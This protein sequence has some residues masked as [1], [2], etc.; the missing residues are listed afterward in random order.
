MVT[1]SV[2]RLLGVC[3]VLAGPLS[4]ADSIPL[5]NWSVPNTGLSTLADLGNPGFFVA[6]TPCRVADTRVGSGFSG[7]YGA[8]ALTAAGRTM[9][10]VASVCTGL[11]ANV[12]AF[13]LNLTVTNTQGAG[14]ILAYP[15]GGSAPTVSSV[16]Y[17]GAGQT[18]ANAAIVPAGSGDSVTF[19]AGVSN[20]DLIVDINGYFVTGEMNANRWVNVVGSYN[21][22]GVLYARN[23]STSTSANTV[24]VRGQ[25]SGGVD[26]HA[27]V[28]GE[29]LSVAG[30][31]WGVLGT[32][33][34]TTNGSAAILGVAGTQLVPTI[35]GPAAV[36]GSQTGGTGW[37]VIGLSTYAGVVGALYDGGGT[38]QGSGRL[39]YST[40]GVYSFGN[41]GA[42][43]TKSFVE[44]HP[45]D[46]TKVIKYVSLEGPEAGTYF[47]GRGRF[48]GGTARIEVPESFRMVSDTE[49][50]TV[51]ITPIGRFAQVMVSRMDL[52]AI[53]VESTKDVE[54]SYL[55]Q[56][57]RKAYREFQP[58]VDGTEYRPEHPSET[59]PAYLS[60]DVKQRLVANGTYNADGT[61]NM[62]TAERV[63]WAKIWRDQEAEN[64]RRAQEPKVLDAQA[65]GIDGKPLLP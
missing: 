15:A 51:Q 65:L 17:T 63:G 37:G 50:L 57:V 49:G 1:R 34:N 5:R 14:F 4:A 31:N 30:V 23:E 54:F 13:S 3:L 44:P 24:A 6:V 62:T 38:L 43:G 52:D 40:Y 61:V 45:T 46:P 29:N 16:N 64:L 41:T 33:G 36:R 39:G 26:N 11:P 60:E 55:V 18:V 28:W 2:V 20:T 35:W 27:G 22:G 32:S 12:S 21:G 48:V 56:G 53:E 8:P 9:D 19:V 10:I 42:T 47:R 59:L 7:S 58:I 25:D